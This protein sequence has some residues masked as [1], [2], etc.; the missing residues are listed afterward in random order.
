MYGVDCFLPLLPQSD[1]T[2]LKP[3]VI[4][5]SSKVKET[6]WKISDFSRWKIHA[7]YPHSCGLGNVLGTKGLVNGKEN[8]EP[9]VA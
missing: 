5:H 8:D 3:T 4:V 7:G 9:S 1:F 6:L 2:G